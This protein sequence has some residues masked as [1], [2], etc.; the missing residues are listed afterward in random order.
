MIDKTLKKQIVWYDNDKTI[1]KDEI[2]N[3]E[4]YINYKYKDRI[5]QIDKDIYI[6][7]NLIDWNIDITKMAE[8]MFS[9]IKIR[10]KTQIKLVVKSIA[11]KNLEIT[12]SESMTESC[13]VKEQDIIKNLTDI[14]E[15]D[16]TIPESNWE[17]YKKWRNEE[18]IWNINK[19]GERT[20]IA[21]CFSN[22]VGFIENFPYTK[23]RIKFN[24]I[25][26]IVEWN[27]VQI[28]DKDYHAIINYV[29]KYFLPLFSK[30]KTVK[31]AVDNVGFKNRYNPW[32]DYFN[33]L[34]YKDDGID[35]IEYII[36]DV[37][38]CE[39][40]DKY[41]DYYYTVLKQMFLASMDR[42]YNKEKKKGVKFDVVTIF[43]SENG[44]T[45]KG[46]FLE[47]IFDIEGKGNSYCYTCSGDSF[48]P[49]DKDFIERSHQCTCLL[50]DE[51]TMK[52]A[53]VTS[54][55]GYITQKDDRF[56]KAYGFNSESYLRGFIITATSNNTDILKDFTTDNE[57]RW[58]IIKVSEDKKNFINVKKA[59]ENGL[60]DKLWAFI[61]NIYENEDIKL[62]FDDDDKLT[63]L[64]EE[65]QRGYKASNNADYNSIVDD[66]LEREYGFY[67]VNNKLIINTDM[68]VKQ[69][70]HG[71]S[72][73]WCKLHNNEVN[74]KKNLV[75]DGKYI[76][77]SEDILITKFG[78]INRISKKELY[79]I[80][81]KLKFEWTRQS[82]NAE[83]RYSGKWNGCYRNKMCRINGIM[84]NA[85]WR[86]NEDKII[87]FNTE[88]NISSEK[89]YD[90]I[91]ISNESELPF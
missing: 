1:A 82:L 19:D 53:I 15:E 90:N 25:R 18:A 13:M 68:I 31:D 38:H 52:R 12:E 62:Y 51:L 44:G 22:I 45:G 37:L 2:S 14:I 49:K 70:L 85:Y 55:K 23:N 78:K 32:I 9:D 79:D 77:K 87:N 81:D 80:L 48:N 27:G 88:N 83:M 75:I 65:I 8:E 73:S 69:Y 41:Y 66:L 35:Y 42:I 36:K 29:C 60:R 43:C 39:W 54:I 26:N 50:L 6:D 72:F 91:N 67:E 89:Q 86:I 61:K 46:T 5:K 24:N 56:R 71:D 7:N 63:K 59:F 58:G 4:T 3:Y 17:L 34:E 76:M 16:D 40:T 28:T 21:D 20:G 11:N 10:K 30:L 64:Q 33:R 74:E 84:V 57:R 47:N